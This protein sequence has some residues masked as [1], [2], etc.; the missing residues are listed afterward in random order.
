MGNETFGGLTHNDVAL[1]YV[2]LYMHLAFWKSTLAIIR[3][4]YVKLVMADG[5][6][7]LLQVVIP[8]ENIL[9]I[10]E[11]LEILPARDRLKNFST[12]DVND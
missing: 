6:R 3:Q 2:T 5:D 8:H 4:M 12:D 9:P 10:E 7:P 11:P 1:Q